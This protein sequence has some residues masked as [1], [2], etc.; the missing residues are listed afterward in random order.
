MQRTMSSIVLLLMLCSS[1][2]KLRAFGA[3]VSDQSPLGV[4]E[5]L[6]QAMRD[7]DAKTADLLLHAKYQGLSLQGTKQSRH[8]FVDTRDRAVSDIAKLKPGEWEARFLSTT[9]QVDPNGL[10]HVW[11]RYVF[12]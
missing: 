6:H 9:T 1:T 5:R 7:A 8:V 3:E 10:A 12:L 11:A 2:Y 4:I